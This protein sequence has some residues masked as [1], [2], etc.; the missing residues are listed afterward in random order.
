MP[1]L[2]FILIP[3][4][5]VTSISG[6]DSQRYI[7]SATGYYRYE[8]SQCR[9][10][11][12]CY[13]IPYANTE[14]WYKTFYTCPSSLIFNPTSSMCESTAFCIDSICLGRT[15][16]ETM[17]DPNALNKDMPVTYVQCIGTVKLYPEIRTCPVLP[18]ATYFKCQSYYS[19]V[20]NQCV[21]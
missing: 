17:A 2:L 7:C 4:V 10:Y 20:R 13:K 15:Y 12:M 14:I 1:T 6:Q 18:V 11:Y 21:C 3:L 5:L 16:G 8:D 19:S 9:K